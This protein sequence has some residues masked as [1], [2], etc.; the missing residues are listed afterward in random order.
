MSMMIRAPALLLLVPLLAAWLAAAQPA[1]AQEAAPAAADR[2]AAETIAAVERYFNAIE[3]LRADFTQVGHDGELAEGI[4]HLRRP[5]RLRVEYAPPVPV[6]IV[7][8]GVL[9]H[10]HDRELGQVND[11]F[12]YDT[13]LGALTKEEVRFGEDLVVTAFAAFAGRV[14]IALVQK[15]DPGAGHLTLIFEDVPLLLR[16]WQVTDAQGLVTTVTLHDIETNIALRPALF[17]FDDPRDDP[18]DEQR[19]R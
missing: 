11:W 12:I 7:G 1:P 6:L 14:E 15:S 8:D 19:G 5:G 10:Y 16:Q 2:T 3:T 9:L 18:R 4:I 13:P 17:V